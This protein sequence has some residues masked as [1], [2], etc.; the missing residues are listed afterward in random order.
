M[1]R[2]FNL[3]DIIIKIYTNSSKMQKKKAN[4]NEQELNSNTEADDPIYESIDL[5]TDES[6]AKYT[7]LFY[8]IQIL[9]L[10]S[11]FI[12]T[13]SLTVLS[14]WLN[15]NPKYQ[16]INKLA[17][18]IAYTTLNKLVIG[19]FN[20]TCAIISF[21]S[22]M[23]D[24]VQV[25]LFLKTHRFLNKYKKRFN[26]VLY[27]N[28][29]NNLDDESMSQ[30]PLKVRNNLIT[31]KFRRK[32]RLFKILYEFV[33]I[34]Y[35]TVYIVFVIAVKFLLGIWLERSINEITNNQI[36]MT[37]WK[38]YKEFEGLIANGTEIGSQELELV[39]Y[40][41]TKFDCCHYLNPYQYNTYKVLDCNLRTGCLKIVQFFYINTFYYVLI[42][43]LLNASINFLILVLQFVN[44][45]FILVKQSLHSYKTQV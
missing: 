39:S 21:L 20:Y 27:N 22:F 28:N 8:S 11:L 38:L 26:N 30:M 13:L 31:R 43:L 37:L 42:F 29:N 2:A 24:F 9:C 17:N 18:G 40:M 41:Q 6:W 45:K 3:W 32:I 14:L 33:S 34:L 35:N 10:S 1:I 7:N 23:L 4:L 36:P 25:Y 19:Y 15:F 44:F 5:T 16:L 12:C